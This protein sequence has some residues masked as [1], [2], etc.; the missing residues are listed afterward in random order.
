MSYPDI[1]L[2]L[3]C[4]WCGGELEFFSQSESGLRCRL[5][6]KTEGKKNGELNIVKRSDPEHYTNR[7]EQMK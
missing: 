4:D 3:N 2:N 5:C 7:Q 6:W 1:T